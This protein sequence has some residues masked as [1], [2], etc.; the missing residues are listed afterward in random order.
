[1]GQQPEILVAK[2]TVDREKFVEPKLVMQ[3]L[4][5]AH[6]TCLVAEAPPYI[7]LFPS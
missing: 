7:L 2:R 1:M 6:V 3:S 4:L 5:G